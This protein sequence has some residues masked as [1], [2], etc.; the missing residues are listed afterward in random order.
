M[1]IYYFI[2]IFLLF[3][4]YKNIIL[5][6]LFNI[7]LVNEFKPDKLLNPITDPCQNPTSASTTPDMNSLEWSQTL[8]MGEQFRLQTPLNSYDH[9]YLW[10]AVLYV[11]NDYITLA[12]D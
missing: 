8:M 3:L 6:F 1:I 4:I 7:R 5:I 2:F 11:L 9:D 12:W 10:I